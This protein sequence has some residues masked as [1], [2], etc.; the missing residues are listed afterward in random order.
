MTDFNT[1]PF[2]DDYNEFDKFYRILFRPGYAVQARELTQMQTILQEQVRRHG[3]H[4]FKEGSMVV[5]GQISYD[6]DVQYVK[7]ASNSTDNAELILSQLVGKEVVNQNGLIAKVISYTLAETVDGVYNENTL[8]V[9]YQN[10]VQDVDGNNVQSF[11]VNDY[12]SPTDGS[13]GLNVT[14]ANL[15]DATGSGSMATIQSGIYYIN[16]HFVLVQQ[17]SIVLDKYS[18]TPSYRIGLK[19]VESVIYPDDDE[20][21][22]DN[23]LGSPNYAAPGA[24]RYK[25]D[26]VLTKITE[27]PNS[28]TV[29]EEDNFIDL[30]RIREGK[31][32]FKL[33]KSSYA[34]LEKTLARRTY[35]ESG[36]Y[37][38]S[39][40]RIQVKDYRNNFRG[41]WAAVEKYLQGDIIE[42]PINGQKYYFVAVTSGTTG[43]NIPNFA[44]WE[45]VDSFT[46]NG[47]RWENS[48]Y[49]N[50]NQGVHT[51][52]SGD[53]DFS[54]FTLSDHQRLDGML[55][56]GIEA[57]KAYVR[58]YEIEKISTE[59]VPVAKSRYLPAGSSA[60]ATYFGTSALPEETQALSAVKS[61]NIDMS[62]GN[63]VIA[64]MLRYAPLGM[65]TVNLHSVVSGS[66]NSGTIIGSAR[67]R[68]LET[69][70][71]DIISAGAFTVGETYTITSVGSTNFTS[72]GASQNTIG[73]TFIAT[74]VG[75][76]TG[77]ARS[78]DYKVFLFD[79]KMNAGYNFSSVK[80]IYTDTGL[81]K[82]DFVQDSGKT[83]MQ[84]PDSSSLIF[85]LPDYAIS[86]IY[87]ASYTV[88][89]QLTQTANETG[90]LLLTAPSG[91]SFESALDEDNYILIENSS[92]TV[93]RK[94]PTVG[95]GG[96][97]LTYSGLSSGSHTVFASMRRSS[98]APQSTI[99]M[100][101]SGDPIVKTLE[102]DAQAKTIQ[103]NHPYVT[104]IVS[105]MMSTDAWGTASPT[106]SVNITNRYSFNQNQDTTKL[107][108]SYITLNQGAQLPTG[109]IQIKYEYLSITQST[110]GDFI[111]VG[112][113][114]HENSRVRYDQ[115][116]AVN[117]LAL[118]DCIDFRPYA[119][120]DSY[121]TKFFPKFGSM[122]SI[123]YRNHLG[124]TDNISLSTT[125]Q[126]LVSSGI[127]AETPIEPSVPALSMKLAR[128]DVEPYTFN[129]NN[130]LGVIITPVENKRYTMR[131]IGKLERRVQDLEYYTALTLAELD[132]KNMR[133]VD[134]TGFERYQNGFLV[135]SFDGQGV[136][137]V[138]SDD[139]NASIDLQKK[140]L[141]P[142]YSQKQLSL[143]EN[144]AATVKN[145]KVSGDIV[146]L[147]FTEVDAISQPKAS[148][149]ESVN[150]FNVSTWEGDVKINPWSDTWFS[151]YHRPDVI[152]NDNNQFDA[153]VHKAKTDGVLG[154]VWNAWQTAFASTASVKGPGSKVDSWSSMNTAAASKLSNGSSAWST[155]FENT[156]TISP[157]AVQVTANQNTSIRTG[158]KTSVI[159]K[160]DSRVVEDRV[161]D[162]Q[163]V[164]FIRPR[165]ILFTGSGFKPST[166]LN[167]FFDNVRVNN[168]IRT[169]T[170]LKVET[171]T[172][173]GSS[174]FPST[175]DVERNC[176]SFISNPERLVWKA[177]G[178]TIS[179][180]ISLTP[181]SGT[182]AGVATKFLQEIQVGD[183]LN[184]SD[185]KKY[186]VTAIASESSLT[187]SPAY[188]GTSSVSGVSASVIGS[189]N[190]TEEVEL[191][192]NHGE[193]I[194]EYVGGIATGNSAIVVAQET[195]G[196]SIYLYVVNIKGNGQFTTATNSYLEGEYAADGSTK[197][198]VRFV[199]RTDFTSLTSSET[200]LVCGLFDIPSSPILKFQTGTRELVLT[201][202]SANNPLSRAQGET[203]VGRTMYEAKGLIE[204][205][206]RTIV[207]TRTASVVSER[208]SE[209]NTVANHDARRQNNVRRDPL[210]QTFIIE[211]D[212][213]AFITSVD[214]YFSQK[215]ERVPVNVEIR[216]V[217]NGYPGAVVV[218]FSRV[219]KKA[220]DVKVSSDSGTATTFK[221]QSPVFLQ[222]GI[223]YALVVLSDSNAY[224][225]WISET[226]GV[227][228][229][230]STV[231]KSQPY[232]GS[233]FKS[234]NASTWTADQNQ[235]LKFKIKRAQF[236][237]SSVSIE[238]I[239]PNQTYRDLELNPFQFV[240]GS[241]KCRVRHPN[242]G[243]IAGEFAM[244]KS[245]QVLDSVNGILASNIFNV[246]LQ[247]VSAELDSYVVEFGG[248]DSAAETGNFGGSTITALENLEFETAMLEIADIVPPGTSISYTAKVL[249]HADEISE[250]VIIPKENFVFDG[251]KVY[252]SS[253]NYS[254]SSFPSGLSIIATLNP[255]PTIRSISP[256]IDMSRVALT[257]VDN[258]I[259][260]ATIDDNDVN[261]DYVSITDPNAGV[262]IGSLSS[263]KA[264]TL[265]SSAGNEILDTLV[266][267]SA[268]NPTLIAAFKH[269]VHLGDVLRFDYSGITG[270]VRNMVVTEMYD[271]GSD[272]YVKMEGYSSDALVVTTGSNTVGI[273]WLSNFKSEFAPNGSSS[274][275]KYVTKKINFGRPSEMLRVMF[276]AVVP[277]D[278][279]VEVYYKTGLNGADTLEDLTYRKAVVPLY[280]KNNTEF[281]DIS[282]NIENL[283]PFDCAMIKLVMRS[284]NKAA[285]PRIQDF[286]TIACA[287]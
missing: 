22:L 10:S 34:E 196:T 118:R 133:I 206:Q 186:T 203:T 269:N 241:K 235:D 257:V 254:S 89:A 171:V 47:V 20:Q 145:Y 169:A 188:G 202:S 287:A 212:G 195:V 227:D 58:G 9:K 263:G 156:P 265:I 90:D 138:L 165:T 96:G 72:I 57:G 115:I 137:N 101:D 76:G 123:S 17:Q 204:V 273:V 109:P 110:A 28:V 147:P 136:G 130:R 27:N 40:F 94:T 228:K 199:Q 211:D 220:A 174:N 240:A 143:L 105:V 24:A 7:L 279:V 245:R 207:S 30:L 168:Y 261:L 230:T 144:S 78:Y 104:R 225:V 239:P 35:D 65:S 191:A 68:A 62:V 29:A 283:E 166:A 25:I 183:H 192:F 151:T 97:T 276:A 209:T 217:V 33:D 172:S 270:G 79:V 218:P 112:S 31:V 95:G 56:L 71:S 201:D 114:T 127:S 52:T 100:V 158:I 92:G 82:C 53:L 120:G 93:I 121:A 198:R 63:F 116:T 106:Y 86:D 216:E 272:L 107:S 146:T 259:N 98:S 177:S 59:F 113:Y 85:K 282:I 238:F 197:P 49:P 219:E 69:N 154:T 229:L 153:V 54:N 162:T 8:F 250:H 155:L 131:D 149:D 80:S 42:F 157:V 161:I 73:T 170:R 61:T 247:I 103:L 75:S 215:D 50:F 36:D 125:G 141:R 231:I 194:K 108:L 281:Q 164:P 83:I 260:N 286:R 243:M 135:D 285:I 64:N 237:S 214:L 246:A 284:I 200:G 190:N 87:E 280:S 66:A 226:F 268:Q 242:H 210:A 32:V 159:D 111:G 152:I 132:T 249:N 117:S 14:V 180:T 48:E 13:I 88:V 5:P 102:V 251:V 12:L 45:N 129:Y 70:S 167:A 39:P 205:K 233:L 234:Q 248:T 255:H 128:I 38:L 213:G 99:M 84:M 119:V 274:K 37:A 77:T 44:N 51:F 189:N 160:T 74:G 43:S 1:E 178:V 15:I 253:I 187:I 67:V 222:G 122:A 277:A 134:S 208:I 6:F 3:D 41:S 267:D 264:V 193:V 19:L 60:L 173:V 266:I 252:P 262:E 221:F 185:G 4:I 46:D 278:A 55:A 124:R 21:L 236:T 140:E 175:F 23:A 126:Y 184:L 179:G 244:L 139:W 2:F 182:V 163:V 223:E 81:F 176:G 224:R 142:F 256:V 275:S 91:Y 26:L 258:K 16:K 150:P 148:K 181:G 18:S 271:V 232:N 11:S